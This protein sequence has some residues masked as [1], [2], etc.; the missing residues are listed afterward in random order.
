MLLSFILVYAQSTVYRVFLISMVFFM[1]RLSLKSF[2]NFPWPDG[3][4]GGTSVYTLAFFEFIHVTFALLCMRTDLES[5]EHYGRLKGQNCF[6][7]VS[8]LQWVP[9]IEWLVNMWIKIP[10]GGKIQQYLMLS[11]VIIGY[12]VS[13]MDVPQNFAVNNSPGRGVSVS[14]TKGIWL[15]CG[16]WE[17]GGLFSSVF[18]FFPSFFFFDFIQW[19]MGS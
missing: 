9:G 3:R 6:L 18:F 19:L 4:V 13:E 16:H 14:L 11:V 2:W 12:I 15:F 1:T 8:I 7:D 10:I 5:Q 17:T